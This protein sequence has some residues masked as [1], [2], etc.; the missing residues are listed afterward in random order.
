M[1]DR[2][3]VLHGAEKSADL[4]EEYDGHLVLNINQYLEVVEVYAVTLL[5]TTLNEMDL[6][7]SWIEKA[8]IPEEKRQVKYITCILLLSATIMCCQMA[9]NIRKNMSSVFAWRE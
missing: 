2:W 8:A 9:Y 3:Y 5:G 1:D 4:T 7:V 6:A